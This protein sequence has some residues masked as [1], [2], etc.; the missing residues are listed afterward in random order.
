ME[1]GEHVRE[2]K[3]IKMIKAIYGGKHGCDYC[4]RPRSVVIAVVDTKFGTEG[5]RI[6]DRYNSGP[7]L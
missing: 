1:R 6:A 4:D 2:V 3:N 7:H 5:D